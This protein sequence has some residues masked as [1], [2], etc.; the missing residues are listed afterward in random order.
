[1]KIKLNLTKDLKRDLKSKAIEKGIERNEFVYEMINSYIL[2]QEAVWISEID[3]VLED[4]KSDEIS[5]EKKAKA[6]M[7][8]TTKKQQPLIL[9]VD[10]RTFY[11]LEIIAEKS[12][13][14]KEQLLIDLLSNIDK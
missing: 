3:Q 12:E 7:K 14:S 11:A 13:T 2:S 6:G 1:M 8:K 9:N 5:Y 4:V 10:E